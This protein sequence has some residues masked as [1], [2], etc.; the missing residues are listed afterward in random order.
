MNALTSS[1]EMSALKD[2]SLA[3][4]IRAFIATY[5]NVET[6]IISTDLR[7]SEDLGLDLLD[8]VELTVLIEEEFDS[9][10]DDSDEIELVGD[11]VS[12]IEKGKSVIVRAQTRVE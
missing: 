11:L 9:I 7:L 4:R 8:I 6:E 5:L 10:A 2:E 12:H 3:N 1:R